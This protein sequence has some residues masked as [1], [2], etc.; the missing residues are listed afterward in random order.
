MTKFGET[1]IQVKGMSSPFQKVEYKTMTH[2]NNAKLGNI[3]L[4]ATAVGETTE[5]RID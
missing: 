2:V 1:V 3:P 5:Q 4:D